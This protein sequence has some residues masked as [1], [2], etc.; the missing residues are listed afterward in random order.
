LRRTP[1]RQRTGALPHGDSVAADLTAALLDSDD[2][3]VA[4]QGPPGTGKT[5]LGADVIARLVREHGW[6]V[7]VVAQS[8][9]VV[10]Q[11]LDRVLAGGVP[12]E[13]GGKRGGTG[14]WRRHS[15]TGQ[16]DFVSASDGGCVLG[17]TTWGFANRTRVPAGALDL[18]VVEEAGQYALANTLAAATAA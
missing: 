16:L 17:G 8:H 11:L 3:Y 10:E 7:G 13:Q 6:R 15:G 1:P 2:S 5:Y 4:V 18:L 12:A 14:G 9:T